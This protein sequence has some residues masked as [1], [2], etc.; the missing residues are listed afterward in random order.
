[1][2]TGERANVRKMTQLFG[3]DIDQEVL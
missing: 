2:Q 1:M 3:A